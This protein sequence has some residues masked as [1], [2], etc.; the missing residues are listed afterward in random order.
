[1][2]AFHFYGR[3]KGCALKGLLDVSIQINRIRHGVHRVIEAG[4]RGKE[5]S[6]RVKIIF[7]AALLALLAFL[8]IRQVLVIKG[9]LHEGNFLKR[10]ENTSLSVHKWM[11]V[12][13]IA[14]KSHLSEKDVFNALQIN[15][16]K[17][18]EKLSLRALSKKYSIPPEE[19]KANLQKITPHRPSRH[20]K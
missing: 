6:R 10:G 5:M 9:S 19:M 18:D 14:E 15:P 1:M 3:T 13:E 8:I 2:R 11:T 17:G 4:Q 7:L 12:D 20:K 16:E